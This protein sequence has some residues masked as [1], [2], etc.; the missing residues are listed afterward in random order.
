MAIY[1]TNTISIKQPMIEI[2]RHTWF[3]KTS[4]I[5]VPW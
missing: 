2:N 5:W 1:V 3:R 4:F